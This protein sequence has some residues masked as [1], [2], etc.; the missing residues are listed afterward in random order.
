M[1]ALLF[2]NEIIVKQNCSAQI[3]ACRNSQDGVRIE[4]RGLAP[5]PPR[6][7]G[8]PSVLG[9]LRIL[10]RNGLEGY[11]KES[12]TSRGKGGDHV[13]RS[14]AAWPFKFLRPISIWE[15]FQIIERSTRE[16]LVVSL[17]VSITAAGSNRSNV[18]GSKVR[19]TQR[20][21]FHV[22]GILETSKYKFAR[23]WR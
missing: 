4:K 23:V 15:P 19:L 21:N 14:L 22:S 6:L 18:Q 2:K 8:V 10:G 3:A 9:R 12:R 7:S 13:R 5:E 17:I 1:R 20:G 11:A 16:F